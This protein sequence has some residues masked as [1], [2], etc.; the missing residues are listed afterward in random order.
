M[1][2]IVLLVLLPSS[3]KI[4]IMKFRFSGEI[5]QNLVCVKILRLE[6]ERERESW[7]NKNEEK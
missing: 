3:A 1:N 7:F 2:R 6:R 5:F 4:E